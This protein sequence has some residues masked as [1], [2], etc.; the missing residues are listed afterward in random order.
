MLTTN[1]KSQMSIAFKLLC[2][3]IK[4]HDFQ[5][6]ILQANFFDFLL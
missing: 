2:A 3:I 5:N 4:K 1:E 6:M